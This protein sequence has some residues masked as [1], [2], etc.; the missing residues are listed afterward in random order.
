ML[1]HSQDI[2]DLEK[3]KAVELKFDTIIYKPVPSVYENYYTEIKKEKI[4]KSYEFKAIPPKEVVDFK[5]RT[6]LENDLPKREKSQTGWEVS[7]FHDSEAISAPKLLFRDISHNNIK[8]LDKAH[9]FF[10]NSITTIT[11]DSAGVMWMGS[12]GD[13]LCKFTGPIMIIYSESSGL[14]SNYIVDIFVDSHNRM[15]IATSKGVCFIYNNELYTPDSELLND[16]FVNSIY[17]DQAGRLWFSTYGNGAI[18]LLNGQLEVFNKNT[19]L[20]GNNVNVVFNDKSGT[21]WFGLNG[22][23]MCIYN[24]GTFTQYTL[25]NVF[26]R[27]SIKTFF[28]TDSEIW[29]GAFGTPLIHYSNDEFQKLHLFEKGNPT[30]Y[31]IIEREDGIWAA[32]YGKGLVNLNDGLYRIYAKENGLP[33][34]N[35]YDLYS[36]NFGNI[37]MADLSGGISRFGN[38]AFEANNIKTGIPLVNAEG[39]KKDPQNNIWYCPNGGN[40][41]K[42]ESDAYLKFSN[43]V[44]GWAYPLHHAFDCAFLPD[45][46]TFLC[47]Y[48]AGIIEVE[49]NRFKYNRFDKG[50]FVMKS[51]VGSDN[52]IW[53][54]TMQNGLKLYDDGNYFDLT[55]EQGLTDDNII[56]LDHDAKGRLWVG[57]ANGGLDIIYGDSL[58]NIGFR[59]GLSSNSIRYIYADDDNG[60]WV[61]TD[62]GIDVIR[63]NSTLHLNTK[64][65]LISDNIS[66]IIKDKNDNFWVATDNGLSQIEFLAEEQI[67]VKNYNTQYGLYVT[68]F[69]SSVYE[70]ENGKIYWGTGHNILF[71]DPENNVSNGASVN[72]IIDKILINDSVINQDKA[73]TDEIISEQDNIVKIQYY[74]IDWGNE[75][76][77]KYNYSLIS[78][79]D[80]I[81]VSNDNNNEIILSDISSGKYELIIRANDN[82]GKTASKSLSL[83]VL[84]YWWESDAFIIILILFFVFAGPITFLL[85]VKNSKRKN[86]KLESLIR[87]KTKELVEKNKIKDALVQE[88]HHRVKNNLQSITSLVD[89]QI[90]SQKNEENKKTLIDTQLRIS[91]MALVHEMLYGSNVSGKISTNKYLRELVSSINE[92]SNTNL[93]PLIFDIDV[94]DYLLGMSDC[95]AIGMLTSEVVSNSIKYAFEGVSDPCIT[96]RFKIEK[97][98]AIYML[99]DNGVGFDFTEIEKEN[100]LGIRL[101]D[102]FARQMSASI[103]IIPNDGT[104]IILTI[105][106]NKLS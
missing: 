3:D 45:G 23:G 49:S 26:D 50:N 79:G 87:E 40:L 99:M 55:T 27:N 31:S 81:T 41:I 102:I 65:G 92:M 35:V 32:A 63:K 90:L 47:T 52:K 48:S 18:S 14:P 74:A 100:S 53:F 57:T 68:D 25:S 30:I 15:W 12:S 51:S 77:I 2:F 58:I 97:G 105:P 44:E 69:N 62:K 7:D 37:W 1:S 10:S 104:A 66:S 5:S 4:P 28:E 8:Y 80:T 101:M 86:A 103:E 91:A 36:D 60:I 22:D 33:S 17:E 75:N 98:K 59:D 9:G 24:N 94:D 82:D 6:I 19:G 76:E 73:L 93:L 78:K 46:K 20:S 21:I 106:L 71:F 96:V 83:K 70:S 38:N 34:V 88:I 11:Q 13:G 85:Y 64:T 95:I 43:E 42:E 84:P 67:V 56:C 89:M 16:I 72:L 39:I 61:G 29:I 54:S